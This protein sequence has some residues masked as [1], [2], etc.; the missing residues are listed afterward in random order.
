LA[1]F[2]LMGEL[3]QEFYRLCIAGRYSCRVNKLSPQRIFTGYAEPKE[4]KPKVALFDR[5]QGH[6]DQTV[7]G[8]VSESV[9]L[10]AGELLDQDVQRM[11]SSYATS[12]GDLFDAESDPA[13]ALDDFIRNAA[14]DFLNTNSSN[15]DLLAA[16]QPSV[17]VVSQSQSQSPARLA[18][19]V[20]GLESTFPGL[21]E[22]VGAGLGLPV[23]ATQAEVLEKFI[24]RAEEIFAGDEAVTFARSDYEKR[25]EEAFDRGVVQVV[26]GGNLGH[27][28]QALS[29]A[30]VKTSPSSFRSLLANDYTTVVGALNKAGEPADFNSPNAGLEVYALGESVPWRDGESA[31]RSDGTSVAVPQVAASAFGLLS[32]HPEWSPVTVE[33]ALAGQE[34]FRLKL[35]DQVELSNGTP[36]VGDGQVDQSVLDSVGEGFLTGLKDPAIAQFLEAKGK[37][38]RFGIPGDKEDIFQIVTARTAPSGAR[39]F[40][41]ETYWGENRHELKAEFSDGAWQPERTVEEIHLKR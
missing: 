22:R 41:L 12:V 3:L 37:N 32:G 34:S 36:F 5:F 30:G 28:S 27:F 14:V 26:A 11:E 39:T 1:P 20:S 19:M 7:H 18:Q 23:E 25:A 24:I 8:E 35:G 13:E 9:L 16:E 15:L 21:Q 29:E 38:I 40:Q 6:E 2:D 10:T 31:G 4:Q 17:K 33:G